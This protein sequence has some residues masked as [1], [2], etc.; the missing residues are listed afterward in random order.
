M[1]SSIMALCVTALVVPFSLAAK[2][3]Q[4]GRMLVTAQGLGSEMMERLIG[5]EYADVVGSNG[6]TEEG[7][8]ITGS[9]DLALNDSS[10]SGFT[11]TVSVTE[12]PLAVSSQTDEEATVFCRV[13]VR[14]SHDDLPD[15]VLTRLFY[16]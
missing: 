3:E 5:R 2:H 6:L 1:A 8:S 4:G 14:V 12:I 9:D 10:V 15:V 13:T 11:R 16:E 7:L